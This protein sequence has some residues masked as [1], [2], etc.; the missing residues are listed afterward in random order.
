M[1]YILDSACSEYSSLCKKSSSNMVN[2][3]KMITLGSGPAKCSQS[4]VNSWWGPD[5]PYLSRPVLATIQP[6]VQW[7]PDLFPTPSRLKK[8]YNYASTPPLGLH[9]L[10]EGELCI[11][12]LLAL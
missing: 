9:S 6:P 3:T 1:Y 11:Y 4:G 2:F 12:L 8:E 10:S 7:V 5:F